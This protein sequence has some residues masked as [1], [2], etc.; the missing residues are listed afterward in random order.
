[1]GWV[2][3]VVAGFGA[4][5]LTLV[6]GTV[7]Y[8]GVVSHVRLKRSG[9]YRMYGMLSDDFGTRHPEKRSENDDV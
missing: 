6:I 4:L 8:M 7:A 3:W 2:V 9:G 1:M 5:V